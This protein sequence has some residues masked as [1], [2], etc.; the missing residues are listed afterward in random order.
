MP[1]SQ[2]YDNPLSPSLADQARIWVML[3]LGSQTAGGQLELL[4]ASSTRRNAGNEAVKV[5]KTHP[6]KG[7]HQPSTGFG[8]E[9]S[10]S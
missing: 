3:I 1:S 10:G 4:G 7:H 9:A 2:Y 5:L 6:A 8:P